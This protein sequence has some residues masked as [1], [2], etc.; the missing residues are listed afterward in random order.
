MKLFAKVTLAAILMLGASSVAAL[1]DGVNVG[2]LNCNAGQTVGMILTS[3]TNLNCVYRPSDG[4]KPQRYTGDITNVGVQLGVTSET[5][6]VWSV[7]APGSL[8]AGALGGTYAGASAN[9]TVGAGLGAN[10]LVGGFEKSVALQPVSVQ[11]QTGLGVS[12][13]ISSMNL[14][15]SGN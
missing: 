15:F 13:G 5:Q 10:V 3:D 4:S 11:A 9:A 14:T 2:V 1:A 12:A 6:I 7:I 8:K